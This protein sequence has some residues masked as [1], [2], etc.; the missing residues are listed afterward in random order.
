[1]KVLYLTPGIFAKGGISRYNRYQITALRELLG[2]EYVTV[3]SLLGPSGS[4]GDLETPFGVH[5]HGP[6]TSSTP[7]GKLIF[8]WEALQSLRYQPDMIWCAHLNFSLLTWMLAR[9][10]GAISVVQVYGRELWPLQGHRLGTGWSLRH[11]DFVISDCHFSAEYGVKEFRLN[12]NIEVIWDCVDTI[13]FSPNYPA[14]RVLARYKLPEPATSF[15]ILTLGRL[16]SDTTYKGYERLLEVL[17]H[18]PL[19]TYLIYGGGG[20]LI[21][22]LRERAQE[23]SVADR[24]VFTGFI[25]DEDLPDVY[26]TASVFCLIG[27]RGPGRGEGIP[28]TP[29]EAAACCVPILVGNQDGSQEAI[30][31]GVNGY[32]LDPFD[33]AGITEHLR[34]L[35]ADD[36]YRRRLGQAAR[37]RIEREHTYSVFRERTKGFLNKVLASKQ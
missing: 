29:L 36:Y 13:R 1:M 30:E 10:A 9:I 23:L 19:H 17:P 35:A 16:T 28:L 11:S 31:Q 2:A 3:L 6:Q 33:L 21:P 34:H 27:D 32:A 22:H 14:P 26:R 25:A 12:S 15:N 18:L 20:D 4:Q 37:I 24:V 5:W 7:I 8:I